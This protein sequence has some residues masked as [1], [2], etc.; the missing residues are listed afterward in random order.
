MLETELQPMYSTTLQNET[1]LSQKREL[2][3]VFFA[4]VSYIAVNDACLG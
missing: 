4:A 2:V 3:D 1:G